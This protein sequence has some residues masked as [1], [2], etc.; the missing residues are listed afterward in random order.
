MAKAK[1]FIQKAIPKSHK[2]DLHKALGIPEGQTI[3]H[4]VLEAA[5]HKPG[6][7]GEMARLAETLEGFH[8]DRGK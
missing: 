3:P 2:G 5:A 1:K 6:K 7:I 8:K 4:D